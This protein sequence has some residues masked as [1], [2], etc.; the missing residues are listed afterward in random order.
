MRT[1][2]GTR[3]PYF[4]APF[5]RH[6]RL[7]SFAAVA[8]WL[9][10]DLIVSVAARGRC[11][12]GRCDGRCLPLPSS[13]FL[14]DTCPWLG[15]AAVSLSYVGSSRR[16]V[17]VTLCLPRSACPSPLDSLFLAMQVDTPKPMDGSRNRLAS[18]P[19]RPAALDSMASAGPPSQLYPSDLYEGISLLSNVCEQVSS[20]PNHPLGLSTPTT[21]A[22]GLTRPRDSVM[23]LLLADVAGGPADFDQAVWSGFTAGQ[24]L[25]PAGS[26][27]QI[28]PSSPI[29]PP[30][31][32][33]CPPGPACFGPQLLGVAANAGSELTPPTTTVPDGAPTAADAPITPSPPRR[34]PRRRADGLA[35]KTAKPRS[36][37]RTSGRKASPGSSTSSLGSEADSP[38]S[39]LPTAEVAA[40]RRKPATAAGAPTHTCKVPGCNR[41]FART[42]NLSTHMRTHTGDCPYACEDKSCA[43]KFKWK[44]SLTSHRKFHEKR[45]AE[46]RAA[47][48]AAAASSGAATIASA[49]AEAEMS[50]AEST[51]NEAAT[52]GVATAVAPLVGGVSPLASGGVVLAK[53]AQVGEAEMAA[54]ALAKLRLEGL[55]G[56]PGSA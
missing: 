26:S 20:T 14:A 22:P 41:A 10:F 17:P 7:A 24:A 49:A 28:P 37:A 54:T 45:E 30:V 15:R 34:R 36:K 3:H 2:L 18:P 46:A 8:V 23:A 51:E 40:G 25:K 21:P 33:H 27:S 16:C 42:Y 5:H 56:R 4:V 29:S 31:V 43:K 12:T 32:M 6:L 35:G 13:S 50:T 47:A 44:S 38:A 11:A 55:A 1:Q 52:A 39:P 53:V 19:T 48:A 9:R